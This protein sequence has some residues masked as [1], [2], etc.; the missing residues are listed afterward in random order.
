MAKIKYSALVSDMRNKLNGSVLSKNRYG[1]YM[2]NKV[3]PVN[4]NT[5][6]QLAVRNR[7]SALS[8]QWRSLTQTQRE[9]WSGAVSDWTG[10]NIFGDIVKPTGQTL[11]IKV[12]ANL[13][14][15]SASQVTMPPAKVGTPAISGFSFTAQ[16]T[17]PELKLTFAPTP[18]PANTA[19]IVE[20]TDMLSAGISSMDN[21]FRQIAVLPATTATGEDVLVAYTAKFGTLVAGKKIG[22]RVKFI[23]TVTGEASLPASAQVI[24][25]A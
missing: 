5:P 2:R 8:S 7:L 12:N 1:S 18:V 22:V 9:A 14:N 17:A 23:N 4:R 24:I 15:V 6:S 10:T 19:M 20:A 3:T 21:K 11:F 13:L 16:Q 25:A